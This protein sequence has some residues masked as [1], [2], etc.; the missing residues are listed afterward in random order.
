[1]SK[2][3]MIGIFAVMASAGAAMAQPTTWYIDQPWEFY[4]ASQ[5]PQT[6]LV[7]TVTWDRSVSNY[8]PASWSLTLSHFDPVFTPDY[9][10]TI[11][12]SYPNVS[13][14]SGVAWDF[15]RDA[16]TMVR[17]GFGF[18]TSIVNVLLDGTQ[19]TVSFAASEYVQI[20]PR[21]SQRLIYNGTMSLVPAPGAMGALAMGGLV[22]TRR[23]R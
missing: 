2:R 11:A 21:S 14:A 18:N 7:G 9:P 23:R 17:L 12:G 6:R 22:A 5:E 20:G 10:I 13:D 15:R 1:M 16:F 4:T 3:G 8:Y 19:D